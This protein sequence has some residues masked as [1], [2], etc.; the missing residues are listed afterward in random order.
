[1]EVHCV[2]VFM[3]YIFLLNT[4]VCVFISH[5]IILFVG[6]V[7]IFVMKRKR[8]VGSVDALLFAHSRCET[9]TKIALH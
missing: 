3:C 9:A 1:M 7:F 8:M 2:C 4:K 6:F 5:G